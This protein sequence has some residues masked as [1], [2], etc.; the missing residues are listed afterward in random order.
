MKKPNLGKVSVLIQER[1]LVAINRVCEGLGVDFYAWL[2]SA[3]RAQLNRDLKV[4]AAKKRESGRHVDTIPGA[5]RGK[6]EG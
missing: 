2:R 3:V 5:G 4:L 6:G 1:E